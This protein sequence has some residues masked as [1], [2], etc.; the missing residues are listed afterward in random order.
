MKRR[1]FLS[2]TAMLCAGG[3][4]LPA[5][6]AK[7]PIADPIPTRAFPQTKFHVVVACE[8]PT[9]GSLGDVVIRQ[10]ATDD[11]GEMWKFIEQ[12]ID[13]WPDLYQLV[14]FVDGKLWNLP[15]LPPLIQEHWAKH[16][17]KG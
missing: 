6:L 11:S 16:L 10:F 13:K 12:Y 14:I 8:W 1:A 15:T 17:I 9:E 2:A 7:G 4:L 3:P 5:V